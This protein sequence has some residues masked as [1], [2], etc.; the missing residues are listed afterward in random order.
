MKEILSCDLGSLVI[1]GIVEV[2]MRWLGLVV[3]AEAPTGTEPLAQLAPVNIQPS[4]NALHLGPLLQ[5]FVTS[6]G[7]EG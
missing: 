3:V 6:C 5:I 4:V 2:S 1:R 7:G